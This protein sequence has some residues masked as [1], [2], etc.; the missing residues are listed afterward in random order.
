MSEMLGACVLEGV[1]DSL[2]K[3]ASLVECFGHVAAF[4]ESEK[5]VSL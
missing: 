3:G 5:T 4:V 2:P 1:A